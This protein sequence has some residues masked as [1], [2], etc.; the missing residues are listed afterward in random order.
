[1]IFPIHKMKDFSLLL[2]TFTY[3][4]LYQERGWFWAHKN[5]V[6][7]PPMSVPKYRD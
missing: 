6:S 3:M 7:N 4:Y 2:H 1:M 5:Q